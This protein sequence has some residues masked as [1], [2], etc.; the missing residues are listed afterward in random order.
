M[1]TQ[2]TSTKSLLQ[3]LNEVF[4]L[5]LLTF[6]RR[7]QIIKKTRIFYLELIGH[8]R[9]LIEVSYIR[10]RGEKRNTRDLQH[11]KM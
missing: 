8:A 2:H 4:S 9:D 5:R 1:T 10:F 7:P 11:E 6:Y 3:A